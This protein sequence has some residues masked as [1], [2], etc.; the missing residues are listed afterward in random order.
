M[1]SATF[2]VPAL[3]IALLPAS[4]RARAKDY[5]A[6]SLEWLP[7]AA[8]AARARAQFTVA[9]DVD[10]VALYATGYATTNAAPPAVISPYHATLN[11]F[12]ADRQMFDKD[13]IWTNFAGSST[14]PFPLPFPIWLPKATT[15]TA[16][17]TDLTTAAAVV[18]LTLHGFIMHDYARTTSRTY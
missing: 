14:S 5:A 10:F 16:V 2:E 4:D 17:L 9:S 7:I 6:Y 18:R 11:L 13:V 1:A 15:V 3:A 12:V 8:N